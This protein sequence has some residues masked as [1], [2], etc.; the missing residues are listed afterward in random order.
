MHLGRWGV[1]P[2]MHLG[3][4]LSAKG[5]VCMGGCLP[6]GV[7]WG[8]LPRGCLP[9]GCLP[10]EMATDVVNTHPTGIPLCLLDFLNMC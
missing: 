7:C 10:H 8:Y 4:G 2:S 1:Y 9:G 5:V 3:R 6:G